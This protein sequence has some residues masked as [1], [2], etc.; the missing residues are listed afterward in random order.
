MR[1]QAAVLYEM[2]RPRPYA[3][4]T[5]LVIE[6]LELEGP[7]A[8]EVLVEVAAAGLCH[9]DLSTINGSRP[10][11]LPMVLGHE[12]SGVV[13]DVGPGVVDLK[14]DDR[15]VFSFVPTCGRC[16]CCA[17]GRPALC[18]RGAAA[19]AA[20]TLLGGGVRFR[21]GGGGGAPVLHHLGV[22]GFSRYTVAAQES[23]VRIDAAVPLEKAAL[24]GCAILTGVGAI[25]NTAK[26]TPGQSV[27]VFGLGGVGLSAVMGAKLAGASVIIAVD[28]LP[29]KLELARKLGA[30]HTVNPK[31][32]DAVRTI[33]EL[34][35]GGAD[36]A[37]EA[38]GSAAVLQLAYGCTRRGGQTVT[39]GLPDPSEQLT[40][41]ALSLTAQEKVLR[42]SY[43]GSAVPRRDI[44]RLIG[45]YLAGALPVDELIS[46]SVALHEINLGF[47]R[48]SD[49]TAVR[50]LVH[51]D[52]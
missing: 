13:R 16:L 32:V 9:S 23:L 1:T 51:F 25:T 45:L 14:P 11:P 29:S 8:G 37:V 19:N 15:V 12:A 47:D 27:A 48:L 7:G 26:V 40:I 38:V 44:P 46:P 49:G 30:H 52:A 22:S 3:D 33:A 18:E 50:Q 41:P 2:A 34:T 10:R 6:D 39:V 21:R 28:P 42:G 24:F 4:S 31:Q 35:A 5:P 36:V 17:T 43:M 20:G